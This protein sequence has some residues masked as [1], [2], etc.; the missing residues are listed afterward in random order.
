MT[1]LIPVT[2][3]LP[4]VCLVTETPLANT[5]IQQVPLLTPVIT[6]NV[7]LLITLRFKFVKILSSLNPLVTIAPVHITQRIA[8]FTTLLTRIQKTSWAAG[9]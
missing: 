8:A 7:P 6:P 2:F 5:Q 9:V 4:E 3:A 1:T